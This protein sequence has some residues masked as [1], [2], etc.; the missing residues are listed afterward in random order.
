MDKKCSELQ[1]IQYI[2]NELPENE[3]LRTE[4]HFAHCDQCRKNL[5][6][7]RL[8]R[9]ALIHSCRVEVSGD[10]VSSVMADIPL[11]LQNFLKTFREKVLAAAAAIILTAVCFLSYFVGARAQ[12]LQDITSISWWN[13]VFLNL[14][15]IITDTFLFVLY[16][17]RILASVGIFVVEGLAFILKN[18]GKLLLFSPQGH[19]V[20]FTVILL[21]VSTAVLVMWIFH[22]TAQ[23]IH[24]VEHK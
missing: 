8:I 5:F 14:F 24:R 19:T 3:M 6:N 22:P 7:H 2:E 15:S 1:V 23:K 4:A 11:P 18:L 10:F 13:G 12:N 16:L 21:F 20:F 9:N 17:V